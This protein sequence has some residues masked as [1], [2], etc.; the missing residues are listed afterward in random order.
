VPAANPEGIAGQTPTPVAIH[1]ARG[2]RQSWYARPVILIT[3]AIAI[4]VIVAAVLGGVALLG[5]FSPLDRSTPTATVT[6]YFQALESQNDSRAW[7]YTAQSRNNASQQSAFIS[8]LQADDARYGRVTSFQ[9]GTITTDGDGNDQ[10][11]VSVMRSKQPSTS[12]TYMLS[13]SQYN[14]ST[15]LIDSVSGS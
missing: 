10:M 12:L 14:G 1:R 9:V 11:S 2:G 8:G 5:L 13:L 6:G 15:W 4:A 3:A 7:Q